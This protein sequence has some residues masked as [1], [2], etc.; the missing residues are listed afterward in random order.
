MSNGSSKWT[1]SRYQKK[2]GT[3]TTEWLNTEIGTR[4]S[5][6][7]IQFDVSSLLE[8][9]LKAIRDYYSKWYDDAVAVAGRSTNTPNS[10]SCAS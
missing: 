2:D 8:N 3:I 7:T 9:E 4:Y 6:T 10:G 5:T 1:V